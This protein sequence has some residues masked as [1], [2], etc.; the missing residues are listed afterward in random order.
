MSIKNNL[1]LSFLMQQN[2]L[3]TFRLFRC[4][5]KLCI[6]FKFWRQIYKS[7]FE[8]HKTNLISIS[9]ISLTVVAAC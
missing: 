4:S 8:E 2:L 6:N 1:C 5:M 3:T 9:E 7:F